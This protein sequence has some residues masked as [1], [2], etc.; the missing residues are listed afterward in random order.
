MPV[1]NTNG[2]DCYMVSY[3]RGI[4]QNGNPSFTELA[5]PAA[6]G[7]AS[8]LLS[9]TL[10]GLIQGRLDQWNAFTDVFIL[11]HGFWKS[12]ADAASDFTAWING[13]LAQV[14]VNPPDKSFFPLIVATHWPSNPLE[15]GPWPFG[16]TGP[17]QAPPPT[18]STLVDDA[19]N[20]LVNF[21]NGTAPGSRLTADVVDALNDAIADAERQ[22]GVATGTLARLDI[23]KGLDDLVAWVWLIVSTWSAANDAFLILWNWVIKYFFDLLARPVFADYAEL[24][25]LFGRTAVRDLTAKLFKA[26]GEWNLRFHMMGHSLGAGVTAGALTGQAGSPSAV[27]FNSIFLAQG[28]ISTWSFATQVPMAGNQ[29]GLYVPALNIPGNGGRIAVAT[30]SLCDFMVRYPYPDAAQWAG[31]SGTTETVTTGQASDYQGIGVAGIKGPLA[32]DSQPQSL[33]PTGETFSSYGVYN[34][35]ATGFINGHS[36]IYNPTIAALYWDMV[37]TSILE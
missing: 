27:G 13:V 26:G 29:P 10:A 20:A 3:Q 33:P 31:W 2:P 25:G 30:Q 12:E 17:L 4:D 21:A 24:A 6:T 34:V 5:D 7:T 15:K 1:L 35:D 28:A 32:G 22:A 11:N 36:D 23:T 8:N 16:A 19:L 14:A 9:D 18:G 37:K